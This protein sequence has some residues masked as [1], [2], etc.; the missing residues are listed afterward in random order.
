MTQ[1]RQ[2]KVAAII[3]AAGAGNRIGRA[4]ALLPLGDSNF[5]DSIIS[6][7]IE[8]GISHII[9][10]ISPEVS[11]KLD[12]KNYDVDFAVNGEKHADMWSSL[13]IGV[14]QL[15]NAV[16]CLIIPVDHPFVKAETFRLLTESFLRQPASIIVPTYQEQ[17]GHPVVLPFDWAK[18]LLQMRVEGGLRSAVKQSRLTVIRI[19]TGDNG[20][21]RNINEPTDLESKF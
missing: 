18:T 10:V 13:L 4:K 6:H 14:A 7:L 3:L 1:P 16:G 19:E 5:L 15:R 2:E 8:A 20:I 17:S 12:A 11:T 9:A 21:L